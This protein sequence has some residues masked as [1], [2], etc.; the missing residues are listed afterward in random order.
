MKFEPVDIEKI[1][2]LFED[3]LKRTQ[4]LDRVEK[5]KLRGKIRKEISLVLS[6]KNP[7]PDTVFNRW[8]ESLS[9]VFSLFPRRFRDDLYILLINISKKG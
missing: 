7:K 2:Q 5:M 6:W 4:Q 9:D 3:G 8:K 1:R